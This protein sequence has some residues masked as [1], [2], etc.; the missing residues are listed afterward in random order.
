MQS[1][2]FAYPTNLISIKGR[3]KRGDGG[4]RHPTEKP[5]DLLKYLVRT[6]SNPGETVLDFCMGS[7]SAGAACGELG[8]NFLGCDLD[9]NYYERC[10]E[11]IKSAFR[12]NSMKVFV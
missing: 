5:V 6:Y 7:G 8:R 2:G 3:R 1:D 11:R 12:S 4:K 10:E 9:L